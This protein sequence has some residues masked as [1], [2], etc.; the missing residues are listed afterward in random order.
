MGVAAVLV[1]AIGLA[2]GLKHISQDAH[3]EE[4]PALYILMKRKT[5]FGT[6]WH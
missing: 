4:Q 2:L 5:Y 1:S 3:G 6:K